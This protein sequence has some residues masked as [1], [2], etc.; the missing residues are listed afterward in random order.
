MARFI[1]LRLEKGSG[2]SQAIRP[3]A[4]HIAQ[5]VEVP[6]DAVRGQ[7]HKLVF[8]PV[9]GKPEVLREG[10][11]KDTDGMRIGYAIKN[12]NLITSAETPHGRGKI[13]H[14]I[15]GQ[16]SRFFERQRL[17]WRFH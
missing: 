11:V 14:T 4:Y 12:T 13:A 15:D 3:E 5:L 2:I 9:M 1:S 16:D 8:V 7:A 6:G 17:A 10:R